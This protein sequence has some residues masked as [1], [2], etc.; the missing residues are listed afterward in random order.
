[1]SLPYTVNDQKPH[2]SFR[3]I[4][5]GA[6]VT[7]D[8]AITSVTVKIRKPNATE[9][10]KTLAK[11]TLAD[12]SKRWEADFVAGDLDA[13]GTLPGEIIVWRGTAPQH[14]L[15]P[16]EFIVRPEYVEVFS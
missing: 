16:L 5:D 3:L 4:E 7:D 10:T 6:D 2:L 11:V 1:M 8:S 13:A 14:G 9:I 15:E 12:G